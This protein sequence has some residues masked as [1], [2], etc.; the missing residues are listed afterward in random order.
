MNTFLGALG[1]YAVKFIFIVGVAI[2]GVC[3]G[4][5]LRKRKDAKNALA[6]EKGNQEE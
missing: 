4:A 3:L 6:A 1:F 2:A 5:T